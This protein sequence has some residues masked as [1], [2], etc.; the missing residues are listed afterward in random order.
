MYRILFACIFEGGG[1][2]ILVVISFTETMLPVSSAEYQAGR[3][4]FSELHPRAVSNLQMC[5]HIISFSDSLI[6]FL[7]VNMI[8]ISDSAK[9]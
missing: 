5:Y 7:I 4:Q 3:L 8:L 9:G 1:V 6:Q 2:Y